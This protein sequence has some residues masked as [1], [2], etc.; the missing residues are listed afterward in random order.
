MS[1]SKKSK[2]G[3]SRWSH[4]Q[5]QEAIIHA[6]SRIGYRT[7]KVSA[8][9][10]SQSCHGCKARIT[11]RKNRTVWCGVCKTVLDRD[12]NAAMNIAKFIFPVSK[13][14]NGGI[15]GNS[16]VT[17]VESKEVF[18]ENLPLFCQSLTRMAT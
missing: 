17:F 6:T 18:Q 11:H 16:G 5:Q 7:K 1:G 9:N 4:S 15:T 2:I 13:K 14:L 12:F 8:K 3:S 10:T